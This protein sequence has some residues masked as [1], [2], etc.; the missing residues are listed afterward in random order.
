MPLLLQNFTESRKDETS[1]N[2]MQKEPRNQTN[3][4]SKIQNKIKTWFKE[5]SWTNE[6]MVV[7][8]NETVYFSNSQKYLPKISLAH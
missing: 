4:Q 8:L 6:I 5:Y 1:H 2:W 3:K 7:K